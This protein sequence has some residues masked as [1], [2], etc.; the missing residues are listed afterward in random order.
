MIVDNEEEKKVSEIRDNIYHLL[1]PFKR[2]FNTH[3]HARTHTYVEL[4]WVLKRRKKKVKTIRINA[5]LYCYT[6]ISSI[7]VIRW[8]AYLHEN[9]L[10]YQI[11]RRLFVFGFSRF[12]TFM[13]RHNLI[14]HSFVLLLCSVF[15]ATHNKNAHKSKTEM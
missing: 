15:L 14:T 4:K 11:K 5:L 9:T 13:L 7:V 12:E 1:M 8:S 10:R 6:T 3:T 2:S